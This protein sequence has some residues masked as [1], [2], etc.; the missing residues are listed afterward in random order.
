MKNE[1]AVSKSNTR[2]ATEPDLRKAILA[3]HVEVSQAEI[4]GTQF[5]VMVNVK[6]DFL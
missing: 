6:F 1:M 3:E 4:G 5:P 2:E